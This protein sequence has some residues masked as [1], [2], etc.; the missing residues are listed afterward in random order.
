MK[1]H[2]VRSECQEHLLKCALCC[3]SPLIQILR[4]LSAQRGCFYFTNSKRDKLLIDCW[5]CW[6]NCSKVN[7]GQSWSPSSSGRWPMR[8]KAEVRVSFL[9]G[10]SPGSCQQTAL[11]HIYTNPP[12][13]KQKQICPHFVSV[14]VSQ[15]PRFWTSSVR[16][17]WCCITLCAM[18][19]QQ[20]WPN[21]CTWLAK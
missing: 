6:T 15:T 18:W 1:C 3:H 5:K 20:G 21:N 12:L 7:R 8:A 17:V 11:P 13:F 10:D 2:S 4:A 9:V 16:V 19:R 14:H